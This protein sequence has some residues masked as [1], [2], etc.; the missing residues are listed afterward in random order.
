MVYVINMA[1]RGNPFTQELIETARRLSAPGKGILAADES[2]G[3]IGSRF[4]KINVENNYENRQAYRALLFTTP[5]IN[6]YISGVIQYEETLENKLE[7][8]TS[9][10]VVLQREG[11]IPGIK[12]D[13]GT[14][15]IPGTDGETATQGLD[16]LAER[17]KAYYEKGC[18]FA[19]WRAV[20]KIGPN[21]PS[22]RAIT[23]NAHNLARYAVICQANGLVPIVEP[24]VLADGTHS[25]D[26]CAEKSQRVFSAVVYALH[27][28]GVLLEGIL[29]KPNMIT[30]GASA[31]DRANPGDVAWRTIQVLNRTLPS[32][33][34][35]VVFLSGGQT[36]EE[37]SVGLNAIN[38]IPNAKRPWALSFSF[39]RALQAS[40]LKAWQGKP[41]NIEAAQQA[42]L[43]RAEANSKATLG[44]YEGG[45]GGEGANQSLYVSNYVY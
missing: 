6:R 19:K 37:A 4:A 30:S 16:G 31:T 12:V 3:T 22:E 44:Q 43:T 28:Q 13:K 36:E 39:G 8:G 42:L 20:L 26:E 10:Q 14:V 21:E 34:P 33:V 24:E 15:I 23:E 2:T 41:E 17:C 9:L 38:A 11:I 32:A 25:L 5:G 7:D 45:A 27:N 29:L 40:T 1:Q 35:G 18:R